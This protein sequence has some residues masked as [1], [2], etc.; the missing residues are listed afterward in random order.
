MLGAVIK[1][2]EAVKLESIFEPIRRRFGRLAEKNIA[3]LKRAYQETVIEELG[4]GQ[5]NK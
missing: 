2:T 3:A 1:A 5:V 4:I